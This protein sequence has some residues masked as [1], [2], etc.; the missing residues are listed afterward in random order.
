MT[1]PSFCPPAFSLIM[2][3]QVER[4]NVRGISQLKLVFVIIC[5]TGK[6]HVTGRRTNTHA[7]RHTHTRAHTEPPISQTRK[8]QNQQPRKL[9]PETGGE[10]GSRGHNEIIRAKYCATGATTVFKTERLCLVC[11]CVSQSV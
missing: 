6:K 8:K 4:H 9:K 1:F 3:P 7:H 5:G 2:Q 10:A 11:V